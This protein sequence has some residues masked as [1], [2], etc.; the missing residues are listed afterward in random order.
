MKEAIN[1]EII[2][3]IMAAISMMESRPG[4]KL[5]VKSFRRIPQ[6]APVWSATG[7]YERLKSK[8]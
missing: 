5:V 8:I 2:S 4:Y 3:V 1:D 7:R 6:T